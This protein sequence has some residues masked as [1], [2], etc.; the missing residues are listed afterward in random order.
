MSCNSLENTALTCVG[1]LHPIIHLGYGLEFDQP[2]IVAEALA[3]A[4][5]HTD[6]PARFLWG[7]ESA[8]VKLS[9]L[10][11]RTLVDLMD[12]IR[13]NSEL[14]N[15]VLWSDPPNKVTDGLYKRASEEMIRVAAQWKVSQEDLQQKTAEMINAGCKSSLA[16]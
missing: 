13:A 1:F 16:R 15:S 4:A 12:E 5:V 14:A 8:A 6:W 9:G 7:A 10:P 3:Q 11:S 2:L